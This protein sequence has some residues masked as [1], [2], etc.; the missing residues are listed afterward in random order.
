M[1]DHDRITAQLDAAFAARL[2]A[3]RDAIVAEADGRTCAS[4]AH[5]SWQGSSGECMR[6]DSVV[7]WL[8][9]A[10]MPYARGL[11]G[12]VRDGVVGT[13]AGDAVE[14]WYSVPLRVHR[15]DA[16]ACGGWAP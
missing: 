9:D 14:Q 16:V 7:P 10:A 12:S 13:S 5:L 8:R 6:A 3:A 4:C 15:R 1:T 11:V 2:V